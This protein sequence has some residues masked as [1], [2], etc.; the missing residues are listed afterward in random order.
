MANNPIASGSL[1]GSFVPVD[2]AACYETAASVAL[3]ALTK[4]QIAALTATGVTAYV[5]GTHTPD[6]AVIVMNDAA[7]GKAVNFVTEGEGFNV[8]SLTWPAAV[9]TYALRLEFAQKT[10]WTIRKV[11]LQGNPSWAA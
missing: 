11:Q 3:T 2:T 8:D 7:V 10:K 9:N 6:M 1:V 5:T 4:W